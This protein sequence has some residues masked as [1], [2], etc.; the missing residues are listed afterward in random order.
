MPQTECR[1]Q[2][3]VNAPSHR[4][5]LLTLTFGDS[6]YNENS[7]HKFLGGRTLFKILERPFQSESKGTPTDDKSQIC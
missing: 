3:G 5:I 2:L 6:K 4:D 1:L 7:T